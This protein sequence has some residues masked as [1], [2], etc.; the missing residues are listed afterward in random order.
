MGVCVTYIS[1]IYAYIGE[2]GFLVPAEDGRKFLKE[3]TIEGRLRE[4]V[5]KLGGR[6]YKFVSPGNSG[7]PDRLVLLPGGAVHFVE[8]KTEEGRLSKIQR[9][10]LKRMRYLGAHVHVLYGSAAVDD[11]LRCCE[12]EVRR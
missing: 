1:Y 5:K 3:K 2:N 6:S 9:V 12:Q 7:V 4:G 11:F 8:L 10:Q